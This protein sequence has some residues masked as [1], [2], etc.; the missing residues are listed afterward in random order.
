M[1]FVTGLLLIDAP[2]SALNNSNERMASSS[3]DNNSATKFIR[4][5]SGENFPYVSAQAFRYWLR[6]T[7]EDSSVSEWVKAPIF[8]EKESNVAHTDA[9]PIKYWDDDLFGYMRA[10][11]KSQDLGTHTSGTVTRIAP[12]RVSTL[13]SIAPVTITSDFG[14]M[15]RHEGNPVTFEHQFYRTTLKGLFSLDLWSCGTFSYRNRTGFR[16]L[17]ENR[18]AI[19]KEQELQHLEADQIYRLPIKERVQRVRALFDGMARLEG[20]AKQTIHYTAVAPAVVILAVTKGGNNIFNYVIGEGKGEKRGLPVVNVE[21]IQ[22]ALEVF[23]DEL[24]SPVYVGWAKGFHDDE[25]TKLERIER[26][27]ISHPRR[28]FEAL[29][30]D[31]DEHPTWME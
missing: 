20:G 18:I 28:A 24:L 19:A 4:S 23:G 14:V 22:E 13:V 27:Q 21:A 11:K 5:R 29:M 7:L 1:A 25:R 6:T 8:R 16:N 12:F 26:V 10:N 9:N 30:K 17:D 31:L 2:A 3:A 15:A